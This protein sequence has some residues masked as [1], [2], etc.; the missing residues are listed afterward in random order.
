MTILV[1][2][3]FD[4]RDPAAFEQVVHALREQV[5]DEPGTLA[6]RWFAADA[7]S[8]LVLEEYADAAAA[9]AHNE[10]GA[11]LLERASRHAEMIYVELYGPI[12]PE[13]DAWVRSNPR[14]TAYAEIPEGAPML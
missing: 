6:Y 4:V 3:R 13:L 8:C 14:A 10:R 7:G 1:R 11:E 12:G 2:A 5:K 9:L